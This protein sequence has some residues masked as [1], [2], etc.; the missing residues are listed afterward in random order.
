MHSNN[1]WEERIADEFKARIT[2]TISSLLDVVFLAIWV[3]TQWLVNKF[4]ANL[5][6]SGID[7]WVLLN[8][9]LLFA[10]STLV[11]PVIYIYVDTRI[12][13]LRASRRIQ[14]E[15]ELSRVHDSDNT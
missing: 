14:R 5:E 9:Q 12:M 10:I 4:I 13:L 2:W 3:G 7:E 11:P 8:F 6:L 15:K 1:E